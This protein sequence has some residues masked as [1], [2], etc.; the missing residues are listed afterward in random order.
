MSTLEFKAY[1]IFKL[2]LGEAEATTL[3]QFVE[4]KAAEK[5]TAQNANFVT[6]DDFKKVELN[7]QKEDT[8]LE[9]LIKNVEA[10]LDKSISESKSDM[11]KW[12]FIFWASQLI[13][14]FAFLKFFMK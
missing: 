14:M 6:K 2:K 8:K 3:L 7:I 9:I 12:M 5:A 10:K 4:E 1:E 13:G 11:I